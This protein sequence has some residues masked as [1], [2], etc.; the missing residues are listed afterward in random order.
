M[1]VVHELA[2]SALQYAIQVAK[3]G[4]LVTVLY[5]PGELSAEQNTVYCWPQESV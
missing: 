3:S 2:L 5:E 4:T 1:T